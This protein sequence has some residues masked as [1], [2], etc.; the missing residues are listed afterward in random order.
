MSVITVDQCG[1]LLSLFVANRASAEKA[2]E[3]AKDIGY[4]DSPMFGARKKR[5]TLVSELAILYSAVA[6]VSA[7]SALRK[8]ATRPVIDSFL[9]CAKTRVFSHIAREIP[10]FPNIYTARVQ[11]YFPL[12]HQDKAPLG[13]SFALMKHLNL[14]P[15]KNMKAQLWLSEHIALTLRES[16]DVLKK[17]TVIGLP[18]TPPSPKAPDPNTQADKIAEAMADFTPVISHWEISAQMAAMMIINAALEGKGSSTQSLL[19]QLSIDQVRVVM[20]FLE[21]VE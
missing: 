11:E 1:D 16:I 19:S 18:S 4:N 3:L 21:R 9:K 10:A 5:A 7:N 14:D 8:E 6:I 13:L 12:F 17:M 15:L 2:A 20:R